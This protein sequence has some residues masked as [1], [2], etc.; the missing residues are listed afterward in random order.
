MGDKIEILTAIA[1]VETRLDGLNERLAWIGENIN[2]HEVRM[3]ILEDC[4]TDDH[5]KRIRDIEGW[6]SNIIGKIAVLMSG[7]GVI[8]TLVTAWISTW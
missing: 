2:D 6:Q 4:G 7:F 3:R 5:E 8:I 1:R